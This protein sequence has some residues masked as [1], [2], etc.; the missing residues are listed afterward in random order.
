VLLSVRVWAVLVVLTFWLLKVR[1][2]VEIP[3]IAPVPLPVRVT[4]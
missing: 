2:L 3:A 1:L 4:V